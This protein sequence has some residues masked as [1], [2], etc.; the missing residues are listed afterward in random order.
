[1][2]SF[3]EYYFTNSYSFLTKPRDFASSEFQLERVFL[4]E[5]PIGQ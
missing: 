4:E 3:L 1:M 5:N 2:Q